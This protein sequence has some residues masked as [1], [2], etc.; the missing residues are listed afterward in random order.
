MGGGGRDFKRQLAWAESCGHHDSR[1]RTIRPS[2]QLHRGFD[3][4]LD[5]L[6]NLSMDAPRASEYLCKFIARAVA[7]GC[8][9][10]EYTAG[11][12]HR[13]SGDAARVLS[14]A[15]A[16]LSAQDAAVHVRKI[17]GLHPEY[18]DLAVA[19]QHITALLQELFVSSDIDAACRCIHDLNTPHFM[20]EVRPRLLPLRYCSVSA[21]KKKKGGTHTHIARSHTHAH[22]TLARTR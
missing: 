15:R 20:H 6:A 16:L 13:Q 17:W 11:S 22:C 3:L 7:D 12:A 21:K 18:H 8:L 10:P 19:K 4:L 9:S 2:T 14:D 5:D 1:S